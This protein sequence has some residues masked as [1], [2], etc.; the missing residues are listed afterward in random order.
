MTFSPIGKNVTTKVIINHRIL[1]NI[2][3][4]IS[5]QIFENQEKQATINEISL[6]MSC[7]L[8]T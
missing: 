3:L 4:K 8:K 1:D 7:C 2:S 6:P 5:R